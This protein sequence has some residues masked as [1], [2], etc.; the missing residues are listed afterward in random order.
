MM[1]SY[2]NN[3]NNRN[4]ELADKTDR[5]QKISYGWIK[6]NGDPKYQLIIKKVHH[7]EKE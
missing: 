5:K 4:T 6:R 3:N 7:L 1:Y 2:N